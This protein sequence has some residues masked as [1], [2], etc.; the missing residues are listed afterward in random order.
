MS[1]IHD[2]NMSDEEIA[3]MHN[4]LEV[5]DEWS[6]EDIYEIDDG[7]YQEEDDDYVPS[8]EN[9][10]YS[11]THPWDAPGMSIWDFI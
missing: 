10:D 8:A 1:I 5:D 2:F 11:P 7:W 3:L 4:I 9:G 6:E